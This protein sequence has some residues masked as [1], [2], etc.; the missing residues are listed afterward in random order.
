MRLVAQH[1]AAVAAIVVL[2][3]VP[4]AGNPP[5]GVCR[6]TPI[7]NAQDYVVDARESNRGAGRTRYRQKEQ[8]RMVLV[9]RNPYLYQYRVSIE[10][11]PVA[12]PSPA[13]FLALF[14]V[15]FNPAETGKVAVAPKPAPLGVAPAMP[16]GFCSLTADLDKAGTAVAS[17]FTD[18][19][20]VWDPTRD[21]VKKAET[22]LE[23][24]TKSFTD[25]R[26]ACEPLYESSMTF[27]SEVKDFTFS[28][29]PV[30]NALDRL[31][32]RTGDLADVV[33]QA[34]KEAAC[35][36]EA[37]RYRLLVAGATSETEK[38]AANLEAAV[39]AAKEIEAARTTVQA[40]LK[41]PE[42]FTQ[43]EWIPDSVEPTDVTIIVSR[44]E[45]KPDAV[46]AKLFEKR[47]NFG[48]R[49]LFAVSGGWATAWLRR[50]EYTAVD[51]QPRAADNTPIGDPLQIVPVVGTTEDSNTR[52]GPV[53]LGHV[54]FL[55]FPAGW[56]ALHATLGVSPQSDGGTT[57]LEVFVG[58]AYSFANEMGFLTMGAY[59]G[60]QRRLEGSYYVNKPLPEGTTAIP[61]A[62]DEHWRFGVSLSF[63]LK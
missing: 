9:N 11:S 2:S 43:T 55:E 58:P 8:V 18:V 7:P 1:L 34:D 3:A 30:Q 35:L 12:G 57:N 29:K 50:V 4:S 59:R 45:L 54:R 20:T 24:A 42:S 32:R 60:Y 53:I 56:G 14:G 10:A 27:I 49:A 26:V 47:L 52:S 16:A 46:F 37:D 51:G 19:V 23:T 25:P 17:A 22:A 21:L 63:R 28:P 41:N 48:G 38:L 13:D 39:K 6:A 40:V 31:R 33:A 15:S 36:A 62:L 61:T 5:E 44:R